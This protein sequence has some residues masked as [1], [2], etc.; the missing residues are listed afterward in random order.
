MPIPGV[1][2]IIAE[3]IEVLPT[4]RLLEG[5]THPVSALAVLPDGRLAS[6]SYDETIKVWDGVTVLT[7]VGHTDVVTALTVLPCGKLVSGS[8]DRTL[9]VW[10]T[11]SGECLLTF[12]GSG[13]VNALAALPDGILAVGE[14]DPVIKLRNAATGEHMHMLEGHTNGVLSLAPLPDG[15]L[16]SGSA[17]KTVR[18]W[19]AASAV[20]LYVLSG[21]TSG[22]SALTVIQGDLGNDVRLVSGSRDKEV[23]VWEGEKRVRSKSF[24]FGIDA[25]AAVVSNT[26]IV[27][28]GNEL[29][30]W[31]IASGRRLLTLKGH[32]DDIYDVVHLSNGIVASCSCDGTVRVWFF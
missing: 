9:K 19:H 13:I 17:D 25:L 12:G 5:H 32:T 22:V 4:S 18:V 24:A 7:L 21:H 30:I 28:V 1:C 6:G 2:D 14:S 20:C 23:I 29:R 27:G 26:L 16:A 10:D 31:E 11:L 8:Y 3:Y 15:K